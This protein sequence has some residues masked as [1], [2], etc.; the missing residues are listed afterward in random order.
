MNSGGSP[1]GVSEPPILQTRKIN[2]VGVDPPVVVTADQRADQDHR[3]ASG[4]D[5]A[6]EQRAHRQQHRIGQ[7]AVVQV[8]FEIN[9]AGHGVEG[10]QQKNEGHVFQQRGVSQRIHRDMQVGG[11][12]QRHHDQRGEHRGDLAVVVFP[13]VRVKYR[14]GRDAEQDTDE[15]QGPWQCQPGAVEG[16]GRHRRACSGQERQKSEQGDRQRA[17]QAGRSEHASRASRN[18]KDS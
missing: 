16:F 1:S 10:Q 7:H 11:Q 13:E 8:A 5:D 6:C 9:T 4:A 2:H 15:R 17:A 12:H 14:A 3:S 18:R